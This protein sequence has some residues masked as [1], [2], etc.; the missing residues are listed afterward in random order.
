MR[1]N[2]EFLNEHTLITP[3]YKIPA[4]VKSTFCHCDKKHPKI[5][6]L[7]KC[8]SFSEQSLRR[9]LATAERHDFDDDLAPL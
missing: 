4:E 8:N 5:L 3:A 1:H 9:G 7:I 2:Q 6:A